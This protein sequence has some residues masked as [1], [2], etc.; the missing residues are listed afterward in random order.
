MCAADTRR[1]GAPHSPD[2]AWRAVWL[3]YGAALVA[4]LIATGWGLYFAGAGMW[5]VAGWGTGFL[6][7]AGF[8][9]GYR[10]RDP[11]PLNGAFIAVLYCATLILVVF[12]GE[13]FV[14]LPDPLPGLPRGDS[15]FFFV[16][17]L[18]QLAASTL[19]AVLGGALAQR[20]SI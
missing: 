10:A 9:A 15:T 4:T 20:R 14:L 3:G 12:A 11:E 17:P 18:A 2:I 1:S 7:A 19:G 16:W 6:F 8:W 13:F 5:W